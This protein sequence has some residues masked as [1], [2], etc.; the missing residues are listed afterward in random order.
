MS[1]GAARLCSSEIIALSA[2]ARH[3]LARAVAEARVVPQPG[4]ILEAIFSDG[5]SVTSTR[6]ISLWTEFNECTRRSALHEVAHAALVSSIGP[7]SDTAPAA[8]SSS[9][10]E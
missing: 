6:A 3:F 10:K 7:E 4:N 9:R 1:V 2:L 8:V 5:L